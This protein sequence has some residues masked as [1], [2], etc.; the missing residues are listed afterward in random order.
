MRY[1]VPVTAMALL[2]TLPLAA[3][4]AADSPAA[5]VDA[6]LRAGEWMA[7]HELVLAQLDTARGALYPS[8]LGALAARL[9]VAEAGLGR[10]E[11]AVWHWHVAQ[12][13]D[14]GALTAETLTL[15]GEAGALLAGH[16]LRQRGEPLAGTTVYHAAGAGDGVQPPRKLAG[17]PPT[18]SAT[19]GQVPAPKVLRV[20]V[21]IDAEG[22]VREPV[23]IGSA[24]PGVVWEALEAMRGWRYEPARKGDERVPVFHQLR[25]NAPPRRPL[26]G[27]VALSKEAVA[28]EALL[29]A[30]SWDQAERKA[31]QAWAAALDERQPRRELVA[32]SLAL[33]ALADAGT[34]NA[35]A[36]VCRWQAAQHLDERLYGFDLTSYGSAGVLLDRHRWG[37]VPAA[38]PFQ[39]QGPKVKRWTRV[40]LPSFWTLS[41]LRGSAIITVTVDDQGALLQPLLLGMRSNRPDDGPPAPFDY[42][43]EPSGLARIGALAALDA[44]CDWTFEPAQL[45]G[46]PVSSALVLAVSFGRL[47]T[48]GTSMPILLDVEQGNRAMGPDGW[49]VIEKSR[50]PSPITQH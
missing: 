17:E 15:L 45:G 16:P 24:A 31:R 48:R 27:L 13:L 37:T 8:R 14:R 5:A 38:L 19:V 35:R 18:L 23:V 40:E 25:L 47:R 11:D 2:A 3:A 44:L 12:N 6:K 34:G 32:A 22:R 41:Q 28:A 42:S 50:P 30:G 39:A 36:A 7:A 10:D 21:V 33:R 1:L 9:A 29:R 43:V 46:R 4:A 26:A 20:E 49:Q